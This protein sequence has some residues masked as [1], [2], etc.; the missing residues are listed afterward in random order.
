MFDAVLRIT[1]L[2]RMRAFATPGHCPGKDN[3]FSPGR[4]S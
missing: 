4:E 1:S 3:L 2:F